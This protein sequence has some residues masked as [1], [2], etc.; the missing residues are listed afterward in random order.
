MLSIPAMPLF[1]KRNLFWRLLLYAVRSNPWAKLA[2]TATVVVAGSV[3]ARR[4][5]NNYELRR[6]RKEWGA[7]APGVVVL[8]QFGRY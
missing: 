1:R 4:I 8:H 3:A 2:V 7:V 6:L 5:Y